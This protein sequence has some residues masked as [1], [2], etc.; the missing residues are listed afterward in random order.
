MNIKE[1]AVFV[2][3]CLCVC[4]CERERGLQGW[5]WYSSP[6]TK[7]WFIIRELSICAWGWEDA[8]NSK[9]TRKSNQ[10]GSKFSEN[11]EGCKGNH[12][13]KFASQHAW[14]SWHNVQKWKLDGL[15]L[16]LW[17]DQLRSP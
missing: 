7:G 4:V 9:D 14:W 1:S 11:M 13:E 16:I 12:F 5:Y 6:I 17:M 15:N 10:K 2:C 3:V 8:K